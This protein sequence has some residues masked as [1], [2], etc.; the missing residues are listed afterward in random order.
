SPRC[1]VDRHSC[2]TRRSSDLGIGASTLRFLDVFLMYCLLSDSPP[3][4][5]AEIQEIALNQHLTA[6]RGR[7]PGLCLLR[8]G[9]SVSLTQW[10]SEIIDALLPI[11]HALDEA[12]GGSAHIEAVTAA[13]ASLLAPETL[14]SAQVLAAMSAEH[15]DLFVSFVRA[16]SQSTRQHLLSLPWSAKQQ[17]RFEAMAAKSMEDQRGIEAADTV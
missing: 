16:Q 9:E 10:G 11:A 8:Q 2:P 13:R 14:P 1:V 6:A 5:P 17:A 7:E 4:T 3:D 12:K 15:D